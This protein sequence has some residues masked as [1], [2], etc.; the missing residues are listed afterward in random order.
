VRFVQVFNGAYTMGEGLGNLDGHKQI[1][2]EYLGHGAILDRPTAALIADLK[3]RGLPEYA[4]VV[5]RSEFGHRPTFQ[6]GASGRG[7]NPRGFTA[8]LAGA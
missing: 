8:F 1:A 3:Q 2:E 6:K 7:H 5:F 4:L